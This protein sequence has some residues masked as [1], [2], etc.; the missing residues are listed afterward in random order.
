MCDT[1]DLEIV[2]S[3][4]R[5]RAW[6]VSFTAATSVILFDALSVVTASTRSMISYCQRIR[7]TTWPPGYGC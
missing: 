3:V 7:T 5:L 1:R 2:E 6:V 4:L